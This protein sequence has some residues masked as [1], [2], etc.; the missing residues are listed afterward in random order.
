MM[1]MPTLWKIWLYLVCL[2]SLSCFT[3]TTCREIREQYIVSFNVQ[4]KQQE[5]KQYLSKSF[6]SDSF[7]YISRTYISHDIPSDFAVIYITQDPA[8]EWL[9]S[10]V[11]PV[12]LIK[13][14]HEDSLGQ[15]RHLL[16]DQNSNGDTTSESED[17]SRSP[18]SDHFAPASLSSVFAVAGIKGEGVKVAIFDTGISKNTS[19]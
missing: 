16:S 10:S 9:S 4:L 15:S 3:E 5:Q 18:L 14:I 17:L 6:T 13:S 8:S 12:N 7:E 19:Y 2:L 11:A 1:A